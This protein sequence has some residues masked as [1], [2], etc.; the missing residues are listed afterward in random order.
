MALSTLP[1]LLAER[2]AAAA[3]TVIL[4]HKDRGIWKPVRW[5][6]LAGQVAALAGALAADGFVPGGVGAVLSDSR[7]EWLVA[8]LAI[9]A[10]GGASAGLS[11]LADAALLTGQLRAVGAS[12][13]FVENEEQLDKLW[14]AR[15]ACPALRRIVVFDTKGLRGLDDPT[16]VALSAFTAPPAAACVTAPDETAAIVFT[17]GSGRPVRLSHRRLAATLAAATARFAPRAG[18]TRLAML[19]P[20]FTA[21]R[22]VGLY[23]SL[24]CGIVTHFGESADTLEANLREVQPT[25]LLAVPAQWKRFHDRI[26]RAAAA[27]T[28]PQRAVLHTALR[29]ARGGAGL[30]ASPVLTP[31]RRTLGLER[32][33]LALVAGGALAPELAGWYRALGIDPIEIYGTAECAGFAA[34]PGRAG[35][36]AV[37]VRITAAGEIALELGDFLPTGDAGTLTEGVLTVAGRLADAIPLPDGALLHPGPIE[38]ALGLSPRILGAV[39]GPGPDGGLHALLWLDAEA[40][41]AWAHARRLMFANYAALTR[42]P[43]LIALLQT[44]IDRVNAGAARAHPIRAFRVLERRLAMGD[45]ELTQLGALRRGA[46]AAPEPREPATTEETP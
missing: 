29:L 41:E 7:V 25:V 1:A 3:E 22:V 26:D 11:P 30:A 40:V 14:S 15:E 24:A 34:T 2:A 13:V 38:R 42:L 23:L 12:I 8:D 33:R 28:L 18:D 45:P 19:P 20:S 46:V 21:E 37:P 32:L 39:V 16:V 36:T 31:L 4:R 43:E 5:A 9:Q 44:E 6:A 10:A 27:A 35:P 17:E